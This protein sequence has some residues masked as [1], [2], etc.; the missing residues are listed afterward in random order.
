MSTENIII[1][2]TAAIC[3]FASFLGLYFL[4]KFKNEDNLNKITPLV[5]LL[6]ISIIAFVTPFFL[7]SE[8]QDFI[9]TLSIEEILY[10]SLTAGLI[11]LAPWINNS[12]KFKYSLLAIASV[13]GCMLLPSD[14]YIIPD[15]NIYLNKAIFALILFAF[16]GLFYNLNGIDGI[17]S[18]QTA[19]IAVGV[20]VLS[21]LNGVPQLL[22]SYGLSL[23]AVF[24][25]F[26]IFN[27]YPAKL[28]LNSAECTSIGFL[29]CWLLIRTSYEGSGPCAVIFCLFFICEMLVA[30]GKKMTLRAEFS[31]LTANTSYYQVNLS[32][33]PP[34]A[35][36]NNIIRL[37]IVLLVLGCFEL[38]APNSYSIPI[39]SLIITFWYLSRLKNWQTPN[40]SIKQ[41]NQDFVGDIKKGIDNI[42]DQVGKD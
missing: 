25:A 21:L 7:I 34:S 39:F 5:V 10:F 29:L 28:K 32:G 16:S 41:L 18:V 36:A 20:F 22:G 26:L 35:V 8:K 15:T 6:P 13:V 17:F 11:Y 9:Y 33:F 23:F 2:S 24:L 37:Q 1:Y 4:A 31:N 40:K 14:F 12:A 38:Y 30:F 27:W 42:K 19:G 3:F